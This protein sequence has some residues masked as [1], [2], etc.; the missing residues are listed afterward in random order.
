MQGLILADVRV[1]LKAAANPCF[2][3]YQLFGRGDKSS[4]GLCHAVL[5]TEQ[6]EIKYTAGCNV[7]QK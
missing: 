5:H 7:T 4:L 3:R 2:S 6:T 1:S